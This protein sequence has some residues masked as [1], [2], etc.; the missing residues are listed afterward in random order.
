LV[1]S[2]NG[3]RSSVCGLAY[4]YTQ[5]GGQITT[6]HSSNFVPKLSRNGSWYIYIYTYIY[7][8]IIASLQESAQR[9]T[10]YIKFQNHWVSG[11]CPSSGV[12]NNW[13]T[14]LRKLDLFPSSRKGRERETPW[15]YSASELY[16]PSDRRLS[17]KLMPTFAGRGCRVSAADPYSHNLGFLDR[18]NN[19]KETFILLGPSE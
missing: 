6:S 9:I 19:G 11:H 13:R 15:S 3:R 16:R 8:Y 12:L 5:T 7:I 18:S 14:T 1:T 2:S 4:S 10:I 17:A